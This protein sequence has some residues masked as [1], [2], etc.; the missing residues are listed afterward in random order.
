MKVLHLAPLWFPISRDAAGGIETYLPGLLAALARAGCQPALL[1]SGDSQVD[2]PLIPVVPRA[3]CPQ[4]ESGTAAEYAYYE[5]H[6]LLLALQHAPEFDLLHSHLGPAGYVLSGNSRLAGRVL[7]TQHN[8]VYPDQEWFIRAHPE[9]WFSTVSDFQAQRLRP[10]TAHCTTIPNGLAV[11]AFTFQ[12][13]AGESLVFLG[14]IEE[15][16]GPDLAV[17]IARELR[18]PLIL[19]GPILD[20]DLFARAIRPHLGDSIRYVGV[21]DHAA[22]NQ[23]LGNAACVLMPSRVEEGFGMVA[24]EAM[25]CG[26]PVVALANGALPDVIE[27]DLTGYTSPDPAALAPLVTRAITL[28]RAAIRA[29]VATRFDL[30]S[31]AAQYSDLYKRILARAPPR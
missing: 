22:K 15:A 14:R 28:D 27:S 5:Q 2:V 6:Q 26:T 13:A 16:K 21:V 20:D 24:V 25:A 9:L 23:L 4:M 30:A 3:L 17:E 31:I 12:P 19:A 8:P 18:R 7:H 11:S 1:A 10:H 29:R